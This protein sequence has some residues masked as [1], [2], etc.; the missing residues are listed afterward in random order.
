MISHQFFATAS[1]SLEV[2]SGLG[3]VL[4]E[5]LPGLLGKL[6]D[7]AWHLTRPRGGQLGQVHYK[8]LPGVTDTSQLHRV[9]VRL[10]GEDELRVGGLVAGRVLNLDEMF[11]IRN[12]RIFRQFE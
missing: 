10:A 8:V 3:C 11:V 6:L 12:A 2:D 1:V 5:E 7:E 9:G 4:L